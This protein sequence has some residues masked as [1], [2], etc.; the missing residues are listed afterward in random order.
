MSQIRLELKLED[1]WKTKIELKLELQ[2]H[3]LKSKQL[4]SKF[5]LC[6]NLDSFSHTWE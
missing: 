6:P 3:L 2:L 4:Q 1:L 5:N